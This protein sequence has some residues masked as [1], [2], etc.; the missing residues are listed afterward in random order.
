MAEPI[1]NRRSTTIA[2]ALLAAA[3][4]ACAAWAPQARAGTFDNGYHANPGETNNITASF[5][6][7]YWTISDTAGI[8]NLAEPDTDCVQQT[9]TTIR[10]PIMRP[11]YGPNSF[12]FFL[13]DGDDT[14]AFT[15]PAPPLPG[16]FNGTG[17]FSVAGEEGNDGLQGSPY[18][19]ELYGSYSVDVT[20]GSHDV[21][22]G[23]GG[24]DTINGG[25]GTN[26]I[27]GGPGED[28]VDG[29]PGAD[30]M[31]GGDGID[32]MVGNA[33]PD[34]MNGGA[35]DD[36]VYGSEGDDTM[37]GGAGNDGVEGG[38]DRDAAFGDGGN[39]N[40]SASFHGGCGGPDSFDGGGGKDTL[41]VYC[42]E[43]TIRF[44]D[45]VAEKGECKPKA[46]SAS[47]QKD[48]SDDLE[49]CGGKKKNKKK[50]KKKGKR[51]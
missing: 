30:Q 10:C 36:D 8:V 17:P 15:G 3:A 21:L 32:F 35:G 49:N 5:D 19:D 14:F 42:G 51:R 29:G 11:F 44:K 45:G 48:K 40:L 43:P 28:R 25:D 38:L 23:N 39:D 7:T 20:P 16:V 41:Y 1:A 31:N 34:T 4:L 18:R 13:G 26:D 37:H 9:P 46:R 6:G 27:D 12:L 47:I 2:A 50:R 33:G 24:D 22:N